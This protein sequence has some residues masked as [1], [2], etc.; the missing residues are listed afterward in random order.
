MLIGNYKKKQRKASKKVWER[1]QN[2][3]QEEKTKSI[4]M[5]INDIEIFLKKKVYKKHQYGRECYRNL[6]EDEKQR[7]V[8]N[9][10]KIILKSTK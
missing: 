8:E 6:P 3:S 9:R 1:Y 4:N 2:L 10:K 7:L 5:P